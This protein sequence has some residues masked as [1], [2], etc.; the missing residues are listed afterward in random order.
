MVKLILVEYME[1][2]R[3]P[4]QK[5]KS[6]IEFLV[7][8]SSLKQQKYNLENLLVCSINDGGMGSLL[9][10]PNGKID[11]KRVFGEQ[12]SE[13]SYDDSDGT[14]VIISLNIDSEG[15]LFELDIWKTNFGKLIRLPDKKDF[16]T[17]Q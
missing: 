10:Y 14:K 9:L 8:N 2:N 6:L 17:E 11:N 3:K 16:E 7:K 12:I 15:N 4:T 13:M 1:S 5:E